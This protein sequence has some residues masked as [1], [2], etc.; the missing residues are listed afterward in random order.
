[1]SLTSLVQVIK[2]NELRTGSKDGRAWEMQ[3]AECILL[4]DEG[5][6]AQVGVLMLPKAMRG[7]HAPKRGV[8]VGAFSLMAG[9]RDR[10]IE[11]QLVNLT[12]YELRKPSGAAVSSPLVK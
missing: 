3:D 6:P 1:M 2:V 5:Q 9:M 8:Y 12:P 4:D 11:A 10:R 7:E